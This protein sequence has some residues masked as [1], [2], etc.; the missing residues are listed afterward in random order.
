MKRDMELVRAILLAVEAVPEGQQPPNPFTMDGF[1]PEVVSHHVHLLSE[2]G[3]LKAADVTCLSDLSD[4]ALPLGI[5]WAG[6]D[7]IDTMRSQEVWEQTKQAMKE[8][9]GGSFSMMLEFG[10]KVAEGFMKE[11]LKDLTGLEIN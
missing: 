7:F 11:K 3:L 1:P 2:A 5:T 4:Q 6:H 9:G 8:A 10:K